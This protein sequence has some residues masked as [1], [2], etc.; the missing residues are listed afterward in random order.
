[1]EKWEYTFM[2]VEVTQLRDEL[3]RF[4]EYGWELVTASPPSVGDRV[5]KW[6]LILKRRK[7]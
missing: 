7:P 4:G 1:M 2:A 5:Q 6:V 3:N